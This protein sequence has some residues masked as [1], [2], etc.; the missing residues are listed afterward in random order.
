M[1]GKG[2]S[3]TSLVKYLS[4]YVASHPK[5]N[6]P[7][8]SSSYFYTGGWMKVSVLVHFFVF[9]FLPVLS[10]FLEVFYYLAE[11]SCSGLPIGLFSLNLNYSDP[12][13]I[14]FMAKHL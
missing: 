12:F 13:G 7:P 11:A 10:S 2:F 3:E 1:A 6:P 9:S 5:N 14:H 4:D 8:P